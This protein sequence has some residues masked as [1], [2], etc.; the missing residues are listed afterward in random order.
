[1]TNKMASDINGRVSSALFFLSMFVIGHLVF[2]VSEYS[3]SVKESS[4]RYHT[5]CFTL[6]IITNL[7]FKAFPDVGECSRNDS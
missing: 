4:R 7:L 6:L 2:N 1:M 5:I 3:F